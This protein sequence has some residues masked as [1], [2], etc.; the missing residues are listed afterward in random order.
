MFLDYYDERLLMARSPL[1]CAA[2]GR[3][4]AAERS[5]FLSAA[6][7]IAVVAVVAAAAAHAD[8]RPQQL[9]RGAWRRYCVP[10]WLAA[11]PGAVV[12]GGRLR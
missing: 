4:E 10:G 2:A 6:V 5:G 3:S 9:P 1:H 8:W 11:G 12:A 7:G